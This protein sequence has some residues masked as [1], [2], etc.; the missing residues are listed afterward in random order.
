MEKKQLVYILDDDLLFSFA[1]E[2]WL[3]SHGKYIAKVFTNPKDF[4]DAFEELQPD[5]IILDFVLGE[6]K[7]GHNNGGEVAKEIMDFGKKIPVLMLSGQKELQVAVDL[8]NHGII[9]YIVKDDAFHTYL[10]S[11]LLRLEQMQKLESEI[12]KLKIQSNTQLR[13]LTIVATITLVFWMIIG[14]I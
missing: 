11:A 2:M 12:E 4:F 3:E 9:D 1:L 6:E 5:I 14:V 10:T 13:R 7:L 8:F